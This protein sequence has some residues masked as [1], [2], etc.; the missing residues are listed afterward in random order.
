MSATDDAS[1]VAMLPPLL[2]RK[3]LSGLVTG[4]ADEF[5]ST[6]PSATAEEEEAIAVA[7][8]A[9]SPALAPDAL[10]ASARGAMSGDRLAASLRAEL[11]A[12]AAAA[13]AS[14]RL[15]KPLWLSDA[16]AMTVFQDVDLEEMAARQA[17]S[18]RKGGWRMKKKSLP[19]ILL[20]KT[21]TGM[22]I[23]NEGR[24]AA[25]A[26]V[27]AMSEEELKAAAIAAAREMHKSTNPDPPKETQILLK[28]FA[29]GLPHLRGKRVVRFEYLFQPA[30]WKK[31][32]REI[33][34][35]AAKA[36]GV[37]A[38]LRRLP[39]APAHK[40]YIEHLEDDVSSACTDG[41]AG[42]Q[43]GGR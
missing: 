27:K 31:G 15:Q 41:S 9:A 32:K 6:K 39:L 18:W 1:P 26:V 8:E 14:P 3:P 33:N 30:P 38:D 29:Q 7:V 2:L 34:K 40:R 5:G 28:D 4:D 43:R 20:H 21:A 12:A 24:D 23:L 17:D 10:A 25:Q 36:A 37:H 42:E 22:V 16:R 19:P 35:K 13:D 11:G